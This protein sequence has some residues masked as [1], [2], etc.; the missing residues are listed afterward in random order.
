MV[1]A[2]DGH[3]HTVASTFSAATQY[4]APD[5]LTPNGT[6]SL[7]T[8]YTYSTFLGLTSAAAP[9][10]TASVTYDDASRR[11]TATTATKIVTTRLD[12]LGRTVRVETGDSAGYSPWWRRCTVRARA[13]RWGG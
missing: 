9:T 3:G 5:K 8:S 2:D 1:S 7:A 6:D 13:R 10:G 11:V 4:A 12:G